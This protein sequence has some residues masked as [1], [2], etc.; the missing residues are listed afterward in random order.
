[1]SSDD[2]GRKCVATPESPFT[3]EQRCRL[4]TVLDSGLITVKVEWIDRHG[5]KTQAWVPRSWL[6]VDGDQS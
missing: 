4:G 3:E 1:M 5:W 2:I 6:S